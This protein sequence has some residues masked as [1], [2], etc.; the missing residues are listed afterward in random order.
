[1]VRGL[2]GLQERKRWRLA[3]G[4]SPSFMLAVIGN[5]R[6]DG[7]LSLRH[8][9]ETPEGQCGAVS[10]RVWRAGLPVLRS[11][12][13]HGGG[14]GSPTMEQ[15]EGRVPVKDSSLVPKNQRV[16]CLTWWSCSKCHWNKGM[17]KM[18]CS[19]R[20]GVSAAFSP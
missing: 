6:T 16:G 15:M 17:D 20:N 13:H 8:V 9:G 18:W 3:G 12:G 5:R 10:G 2:L 7:G 14:W 11:S 19:P 4:C 1:M